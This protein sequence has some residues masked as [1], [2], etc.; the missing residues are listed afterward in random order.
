MRPATKCKVGS[1]GSAAMYVVYTITVPPH[2]KP[3]KKTISSV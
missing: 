1:A 3:R 2:N